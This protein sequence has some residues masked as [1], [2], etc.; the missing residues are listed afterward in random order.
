MIGVLA[1]IA[2]PLLKGL[3]DIVDQSVEDKDQAARI[4]ALLQQKVLDG[5]RRAAVRH[6]LGRSPPRY[7]GPHQDRPR[8]LRRR[9]VGGKGY[10]GMEAAGLGR[11]LISWGAELSD[12]EKNFAQIKRATPPS[13]NPV[14]RIR[15]PH[16]SSSPSSF[17]TAK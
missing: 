5:H 13:G 3:F 6:A 15:A 10:Q 4:K 8:W 14:A 2:G 7:V 16:F 12:H 11:L 17:G 9:A 1:T